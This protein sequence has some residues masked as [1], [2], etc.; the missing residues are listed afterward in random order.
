MIEIVI[1]TEIVIGRE[2]EKVMLETQKDV[3]KR[4]AELMAIVLLKGRVMVS[5]RVQ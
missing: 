4:E 5:F 3:A 1:G 2:T